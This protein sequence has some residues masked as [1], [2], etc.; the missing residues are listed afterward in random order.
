MEFT[1]K[2]EFNFGDGFQKDSDH[3]P[4]RQVMIKAV[5]Q[6]ITSNIRWRCSEEDAN[7]ALTVSMIPEQPRN[8]G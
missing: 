5:Y 2:D 8:D 3:R 6:L 7:M 4:P 1:G